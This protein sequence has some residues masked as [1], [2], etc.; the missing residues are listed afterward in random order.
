[1]DQAAFAG[2]SFVNPR[3]EQMI[4]K[5]KKQNGSPG[6]TVLAQHLQIG[7]YPVPFIFMWSKFS[8]MDNKNIKRFGL[9]NDF[10]QFLYQRM[11]WNETGMFAGI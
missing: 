9:D 11:R 5:W 7:F 4:S 10:F 8:W 6:N 2:F 1:M 3:L